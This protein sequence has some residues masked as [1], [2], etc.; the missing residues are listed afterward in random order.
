MYIYIYIYAPTSIG[1]LY[2]ACA[3]FTTASQVRHGHLTI[4]IY[5][6]IYM[7]LYGYQYV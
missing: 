5:T 1:A 2:A 3:A 7:Y 6:C 4:Y